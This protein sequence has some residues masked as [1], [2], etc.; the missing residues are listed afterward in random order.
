[1]LDTLPGI[2]GRLQYGT[3]KSNLFAGQASQVC[4]VSFLFYF[5]L[6]GFLFIWLLFLLIITE[7]SVI[8]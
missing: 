8:A 1:M 3:I 7:L 4:S 5:H 2:G 6:I